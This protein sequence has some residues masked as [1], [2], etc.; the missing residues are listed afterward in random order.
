MRFFEVFLK[1][2]DIDFSD[3]K[4]YWFG[5]YSVWLFFLEQTSVIF[6]INLD[7]ESDGFVRYHHP[8]VSPLPIR[9]FRL[10]L[11]CE[12]TVLFRKINSRLPYKYFYI[13]TS[14]TEIYH[15]LQVQLA[16]KFLMHWVIRFDSQWIILWFYLL[17]F[18]LRTCNLNFII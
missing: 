2:I 7:G 6:D 11:P 1:G 3:I 9:P 8:V 15:V 4:Y 5:I 10:L 13:T 12:C 14:W 18:N 16:S 17:E